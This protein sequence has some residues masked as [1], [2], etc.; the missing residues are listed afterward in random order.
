MLTPR[1]VT[2]LASVSIA[3]GALPTAAAAA[4]RTAPVVA[5]TN[6]SAGA[7]VW[8][9]TTIAA[10]ASDN[11]ALQKVEFYVDGARKAT[12]MHAPF[13]Y[14]WDTRSLAAG[15][16]P[17]LTA[18]AYDAAKNATTSTPV[19]VVVSRR[20]PLGAAVSWNGLSGDAAYQSAFLKY[21]DSMTPE[22]AMKWDAIEPQVGVFDYSSA[23]KLV[24][25]A[26]QHG[27]LLRGHVLVWGSA[28][29]AWLTGRAWTPDDLRA[30]LKRHIQTVI[31]HYRGKVRVW[32]VVNEAWNWDG[33]YRQNFWYQ[34]LGPSYVEDAFRWAHEADPTAKLF[35]NDYSAERT[36]TK[37]NDIYAMLQDF[38]ARGVPVDGVGFEAHAWRDWLASES[39]L[40]SNLTR[41]GNLGL[42]VELTEMDVKTSELSG[43]TVDEKLSQEADIYG[44]YARFCRSVPACKRLTVW[45]VGDA[46]SWLGPWEMPLLLDGGYA[47]KPAYWSAG[48]ELAVT[49]GPR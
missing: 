48:D 35:Y 24:S 39:D 23:D 45:G 46:A 17:T 11:V 18:R 6:P 21:Y 44:R 49:A 34:N 7:R 22:T 8:G 47:P 19:S 33:T 9:T 38:K 14:G 13:T 15:A 10:S 30:V 3:A 4:D 31:G 43:T 37:S 25:Y 1:L 29:P 27:K 12:D 42:D 16:A 2:A 26:S 41:F 20:V 32:D 36:N 5:V 40:S 28:L